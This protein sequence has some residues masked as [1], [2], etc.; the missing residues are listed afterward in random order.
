MDSAATALR[1]SVEVPAV[2]GGHIGHLHAQHLSLFEQTLSGIGE[3]CQ[4]PTS[5]LQPLQTSRA[6]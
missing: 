1:L 4:T 6:A 2:W 3:G 5:H